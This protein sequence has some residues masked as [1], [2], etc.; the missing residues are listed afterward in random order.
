[1][2]YKIHYYSNRCWRFPTI[3]ILFT[4]NFHTKNISILRKILHNHNNNFYLNHSEFF[5]LIF[6]FLSSF[7]LEINCRS[8]RMLNL[9]KKKTNVN[10]NHSKRD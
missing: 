6:N 4:K 9:K 1:M 2:N 10:V 3:L 7:A 5:P 8:E